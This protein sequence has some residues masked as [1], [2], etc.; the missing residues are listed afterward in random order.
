MSSQFGVSQDPA[1]WGIVG[2]SA[3]GTCAIDLTVMHSELF[4]T[5]ADIGG[6]LGPNSGDKNQTVDRLYGGSLTAWQSF[7]PS[8][9][10]TRHGHYSGVAG[11][12][13]VSGARFDERNQLVGFN[14]SE[15]AIATTLC[16]LGRR[17]DISCAVT[18]RPGKHDWPFA[19]KAFAAV[20]PW[21]AGR[22]HTPDVASLALPIKDS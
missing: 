15:H 7:E 18:A 9:V 12:F 11:M 3:G 6:D 5:F 2:F 10:M 4:H 17:N 19:G 13:I 16:D 21:V 14:E 8:L 1:D 22:V 20:L